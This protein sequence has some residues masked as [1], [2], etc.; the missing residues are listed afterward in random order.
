MSTSDAGFYSGSSENGEDMLS[1]QPRSPTDASE[2]S[3]EMKVVP[4]SLP[5]KNKRKSSEPYKLISS[6]TDIIPI[7]KRI[8]YDVKKE[9]NRV[10]ASHITQIKKEDS[11]S[12]DAAGNHFRP[13]MASSEED[14]MDERVLNPAEVLQ[15][16]PGVTT[17]H[18]IPTDVKNSNIEQDQPL[19]LVSKKTTSPPQLPTSTIVAPPQ[20]R[21]KTPLELMS[22]TIQQNSLTQ[23]PNLDISTSSSTSSS[24]PSIITSPP[25]TSTH[26]VPTSR[27]SSSQHRN[28]KNMTRE[29]RIEANARERTRVHTISA[30]FDTLRKSIPSYS[31]NQKLSKLSILRISCQYILLLSRIAGMDYSA[32]NS[33]PSLAECMELL[34]RTIQTEGKLRKKKDE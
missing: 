33:E 16:H 18:R 7:K 15:R 11:R 25:S 32:D 3:I 22:N 12:S 1:D 34:T 23:V 19:S 17:F 2:D 10:S 31:N 4:I 24:S 9:A 29:R 28:Y 13:W 27:S 8:C 5:S 30:A 26:P 21:R 14:Y 20:S 6:E